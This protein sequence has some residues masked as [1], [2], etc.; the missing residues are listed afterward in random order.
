M[1]H[2]EGFVRPLAG[3]PFSAIITSSHSQTL[4][5]GTTISHSM[6]RTVARDSAGRVREEVTITPKFN[7]APHGRKAAAEATTP[8]APAAPPTP[9]TRVTV[10]DPVAHTVTMWSDHEKIAVVRPLPQGGFEGRRGPGGKHAA[11]NATPANPPAPP[12]EGAAPEAALGGNGPR[13]E[14][15]HHHEGPGG[16]DA[17]AVKTD[18]GSKTVAGVS[19]TGERMTHTIPAGTIGN[20]KPLVSTHERWFSPDLKIVVSETDNSPL[21]GT[22]SLQVANLSRTE[23]SADLFKAPADYVVHQAKGP[24]QRGPGH[25]GP[26]FGGAQAPPAPD[27]PPA[28]RQQN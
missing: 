22:S 11:E 2:E 20:D 1:G 28:P 3:A 13:P 16:P 19:A 5:D 21:R 9:R 8:A 17:D 10:I 25:R 24:G 23:P 6:T 26:G 12:A 18:L 27:A 14:F 15:R 7:H 4:S